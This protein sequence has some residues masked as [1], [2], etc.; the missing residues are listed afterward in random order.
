MKV[1]FTHRAVD[2]LI[3][4]ADYIW[5]R[6]RKAALDVASAINMTTD[7]LADFPM[8]GTEEKELK[9]RKILVPRYPYAIYYRVENDDVWILHIRD[10]R[11]RVPT[12]DDV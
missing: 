10:G 3:A 2:D 7:R 11:R 6:N 5:E 12:E 8:I 1:R 9:A 4:I